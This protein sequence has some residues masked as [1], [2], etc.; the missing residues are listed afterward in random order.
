LVVSKD[1]DITI[2]RRRSKLSVPMTTRKTDD[3]EQS[4]S[5]EQK[6]RLKQKMKDTHKSPENSVFLGLF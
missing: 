6:R 2:P 4:F 3:N 1:I 5:K